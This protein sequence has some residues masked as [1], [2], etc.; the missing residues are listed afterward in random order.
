MDTIDIGTPTKTGWNILGPGGGGCVHSLTINPRR[1]DTMLVSCDMTAG[2]ITQDGGLS[3]RE[4]NLKARQHAY[5]FDPADPDTMY[6]GASAL[7]RSTDNGE[8]W[9]MVFPDPLKLLGEERLGDEASHRFLSSDNWPGRTVHAILIDPRDRDRIHIA[10]K[11]Q[12]PRQPVDHFYDRSKKGI[13]VYS[14][15]DRGRSWTCAAELEDE[16]INLLAFDQEGGRGTGTLLAFSERGIYRIASPDR[17]ERLAL[18]EGVLGLRHASRGIESG[19][20]QARFWIVGLSSG[21]GGATT[22]RVF[23]SS[24]L[25]APWTESLPLPGAVDPKDPPVF[26]QVSVCESDAGRAWLI[27]EKFPERDSVGRRV[28]SYGILRSDDGGGHWTWAVKAD[29]NSDPPNRRG[30]W[31]ER[32]YGAG[33]GDLKGDHQV[34]PKGRFAWDVVASPVDPD[35]CYTMDFSTIF[36]TADAGAIWDQLVTKLHEDGS[37]SSRGIDVL[38]P[39]GVFFDPFDPGHLAL[40]MTD[41]GAWHSRNGGRTW[42]HAITGIPRP[43]INTCYWMVFDPEVRGRAWSVW[44]AMHDIPRI[45]MFQ[46]GFFAWKQGGIAK[47]EDGLAS[48]VPSDK[49]LP[50]RALCTHM[51]LDPRSAPGSRTL[52]ATVFGQGVWKSVDDGRNWTAKNAGIDTSNPFA[53]RLALLPDGSLYLVVVKNYLKGR[54][55]TGALYRSDDGAETWKPVALPGRVDFPNDLTF[56]PSGRLYLACWPREVEGRNSGGGAWASDDGGRTWAGIFDSS[57]HV[58]TVAVDPNNSD[59]LYLSTFDASLQRSDD[60]GRSWN[61]VEGFDFQWGYRP[62]P[63]PHHPGMLYVTTFGSSVWYGPAGCAHAAVPN[64]GKDGR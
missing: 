62:V 1:P 40:A 39:Y 51:V 6:V 21:E 16:E 31:A 58:Y 20:G 43:W 18:P 25:D 50:E 8:T 55:H 15:A 48:W 5:A 42:L 37:V 52:Y 10:L 14:S 56:D 30:G 41:V 47:S 13:L 22:S 23:N 36:K 64:R 27:A 11:K 44:S 63:D 60:R 45:K 2:Y 57:F 33:W 34:S 12:G 59:I 28:E 46:D 54:Q 17:V 53:W 24:D 49:G 32:D 7:Y 29:D 9:H 4:F 19:S 61:Q 38:G 26:S 3:W 35:T